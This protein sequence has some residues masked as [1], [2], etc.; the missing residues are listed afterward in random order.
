MVKKREREKDTMIEK[1]RVRDWWAE[2]VRVGGG[3]GDREI[4]N[5][6]DRTEKMY[7]LF[8]TFIF[9]IFRSKKGFQFSENC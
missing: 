5:G 1:E 8:Y 2:C 9:S 6:R 4:E 7:L 3:G